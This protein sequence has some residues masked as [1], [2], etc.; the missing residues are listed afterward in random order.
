MDLPES[1]QSRAF[2]FAL[3]VLAFYRTIRNT[4]AIL[5][6]FADQVLR[7]GTSIGANL[8]EARSAYSR[9]DLASRYTIA[10]R[11]ARE[12]HYWFRLMKASNERP[13]AELER[14]IDECNQII[15][16]LTVAV[17]KLRTASGPSDL[18]CIVV[19]SDFPACT[20]PPTE[21]SR[22]RPPSLVR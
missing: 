19:R 5:P 22:S 14:L 11:E 17:K 4:T 2:R 21:S 3:G 15:A 18:T 9:K 10:L 12:C 16:L 7:A 6:H 13:P 8:E 20:R 1:F